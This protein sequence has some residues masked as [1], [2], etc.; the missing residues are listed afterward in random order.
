M[1]FNSV[2]YLVLLGLA[3]VLFWLLPARFRR[4]FVLLASAAFYAS[5][6][7][8]FVWLPLLVAGIV[9]VVG[10]EIVRGTSRQRLWMRLGIA[11]VLFLLIF[12]KC[13]EFFLGNLSAL[14]VSLGTHLLLFPDSLAFPVGISFYTFEAIAYLI[15][16][17]QGRVKLPGFGDLCL[18]FFFW[19]NILSGP[20]VRARE[21]MPQLGFRKAFEPGFCFEGM[22]RLIWGL[23]QKNVI[24]NVLGIWVDHGFAPTAVGVPS[25]LDGRFLAV[26]FGLQIYFDFAGYTNLAIGTARFLG[27]TL[28]ENF[29]QP[30]H[31]ATPPDFWARWHMTLSRWIRDYL[32]FPITAK[33]ANT[34]LLL[35]AALIGAM[36]LVG[37]WHGAG[38]GFILWG[39]LHGGYLVL[40]RLCESWRGATPA[41][42]G[43]T[44][45]SMAWK[46]FTLVAVTA[47]WV[48][49]RATSFERAGAILSAMFYRFAAGHAYSTGFYVFTV[50]V[51]V[52]CALEP[53]VMRR[54]G[55]IEE[56]AGVD[57]PSPFRM[58]VRPIAYAF[59]LFLFLL[60][61]ENNAQFIYSQF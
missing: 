8:V 21:L 19:P 23:V 14:G 34:S 41:Q 27:V 57:G 10:R 13:R 40:Y 12:F 39:T 16:L 17:R 55:E 61:D 15:D 48:P 2:P 52:F 29:R 58:L 43:K 59:G 50:T 18:F 5:W 53:W 24:A 49:F 20:M 32:F 6:G 38:W 36:T 54:L 3:V 22:D 35:Y 37:L 26:G 44:V 33:W 60:F 46:V 30:Y 25:T 1:V 28:P 4:S 42:S 7:L 11:G 47:A 56:R 31:A 45:M 51:A 9:Y